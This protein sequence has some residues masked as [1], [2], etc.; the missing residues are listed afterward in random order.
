[1]SYNYN[2]YITG[3]ANM[4]VIPPTDSNFLQFLPNCIDDAELSLYRGLD[5]LST[6]VRDQSGTLTANSR[7]FTLPQSLGR[8]VVTESMN[9]FTP[10]G[11]PTTRNQLVP[12]TREFIDAIYGNEAAATTPSLPLYYAMITDQQIIVGPPPDAAYT[13]EVV[14]TIR[15]TPLSATNPTTY[16]TQYFPDLFLAESLIFGYGYLKDFGAATDD[17]QGSPTWVSHYKM[18]WDGA[19]TEENRKKYASQGWTSKSPAP[20]A[21]PPRA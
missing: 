11:S 3:L 1:V 2:G 5:F 15:P 17:P 13:M 19:N 8:F 4:L 18:L 9:Y 12:T 10:S 14:G 16:L 20:L 7:T 6:I 21:T